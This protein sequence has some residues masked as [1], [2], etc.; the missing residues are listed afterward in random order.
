MSAT[1]YELVINLKAA[2]AVG[3]AVPPALLAQA[4]NVIE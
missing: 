4:D 1:K 3:I 2:M